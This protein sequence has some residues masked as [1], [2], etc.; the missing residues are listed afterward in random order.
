MNIH[1]YQGKALFRQY[2]IPVPRGKEAFSKEEAKQVAQE[3]GGPSWVV[4]AQIHA[5]GRGKG[6]G[7]RLTSS[8]EEVEQCAAN[9]LGM[10]LITPQTTD[11]KGKKVRRIYV[12]AA[13]SIQK[14]FYLSLLLDRQKFMLS[15]LLSTEGGMNIEEVSAKNPE[16]IINVPIEP[17]KGF[18]KEHGEKIA[19]AL[20][21]SKKT[22]EFISIGKA[23]YNLFLEKDCTLIEVN[24]LILTKENQVIALDA[25]I[26]FDDN[27]LS[28]HPDILALR[29]M[30]EEDPMELEA[31]K[32]GLSYIA[33]DGNV[34]CMVNG[35]GLAMATT[36][37][38][39]LNGLSPANFLDVGGGASK[40]N[41][42]AAFKIIIQDKK[43]EIIFINIFGGIMKCD[44]LAKG[45]VAATQEVGLKVPLVVRLEGTNVEKG[46]AILQSS[47]L[48]IIAVNSFK[49][50]GE[51]VAQAAKGHI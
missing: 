50:A 47:G 5:G 31:S 18:Q 11:P 42:A 9:M 36:D 40:E 48:N 4:K 37:M 51:K 17:E 30:E 26:S 2:G 25:K 46:R 49:E 1:E 27:A 35:A 41:V 28:L 45:V 8:L 10:H 23:L 15:F 33:L 39:Q 20:N 14:E 24:P 32:Y 29:D 12:E 21:L 44:V 16:K 19:T 13:S 6:G 38:I 43:V 7:I 34:G 3:I 22:E